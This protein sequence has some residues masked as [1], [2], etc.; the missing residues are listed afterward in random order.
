VTDFASFRAAV[1]AAVQAA[2][3]S[4]VSAPANNDGPA[5]FWVDGAMPYGKHLI[6]LSEVS[7]VYEMD[8]DT[9]LYTG[10]A[11]TLSSFV[12]ITVQVQCESQHDDPTLNAQWLVE[13]IRLGLR[14][15]SV[16]DAL[17]T[18]NVIIA[19]FPSAT[20][21]RSYPTDG[22]IISA[23]SFDVAFRT[24]FTFDATGEDAG[25]IERVVAEGEGGLAGADV[26]V[27]DPDPEP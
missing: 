27:T 26:D 4:S 16:A 23:A 3:P 1:A 18:A 2:M 8:R 12:A 21:R 22:R 7:V 11:Q 10:G 14:K 6:Q 15:V 17:K 5:V 25:L 19:N 20:V 13:Q 24:E 9:A